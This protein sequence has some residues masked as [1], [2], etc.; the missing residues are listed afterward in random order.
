ME[1]RLDHE[2][3]FPRPFYDLVAGD[4]GNGLPISGGNGG[5]GGQ[6]YRS[7][8]RGGIIERLGGAWRPSDIR[9]MFIVSKKQ[10]EQDALD[11]EQ[12]TTNYGTEEQE[13]VLD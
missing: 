9:G 12:N 7:M 11:Y 6:R 13:K 4:R 10:E 8:S 1:W 2:N 5:Q 3:Y